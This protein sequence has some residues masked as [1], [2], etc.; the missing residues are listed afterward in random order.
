MSLTIGVW[1]TSLRWLRDQMPAP[2][3]PAQLVLS[4]GVAG[5]LAGAVQSVVAMPFEVLKVRSQL[6]LEGTKTAS[7]WRLARAV[8]AS[9]GVGTR[10]GRVAL[11]CSPGHCAAGLYP[12]RA[13]PAHGT[14]MVGGSFVY[15]VVYTSLGRLAQHADGSS[16]GLA[17]RVLVGGFTGVVYWSLLF[18]FDLVRSKVQLACSCFFL[19]QLRLHSSST[20]P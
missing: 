6:D 5:A 14:V 1:G 11:A 3:T 15:F 8:V 18:P 2:L 4:A 7:T 16:L 12:R 10:G 17:E 9:E 19:S 13:L 20:M